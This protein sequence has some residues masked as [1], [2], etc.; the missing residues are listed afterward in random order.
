MEPL[1]RAQQL[2][3]DGQGMFKSIK[4]VMEEFELPLREAKATVSKAKGIEVAAQQAELAVSLGAYDQEAAEKEAS[5]LEQCATVLHER[6]YQ[7][8]DHAKELRLKAAQVE[9]GG[10]FQRFRWKLERTS[11]DLENDGSLDAH[12]YLKAIDTDDREFHDASNDLHTAFGFGYHD[13]ASVGPGVNV[14]VDDYVIRLGFDNLATFQQYLK[15]VPIEVDMVDEIARIRMLSAGYAE[16]M[17][18]LRDGRG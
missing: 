17:K 1:E 6:A 14:R 18:E 11:W 2:L 13:N 16:L 5:E 10:L 15:D 7:L 9:S 8:R 4:A 3:A 12:I